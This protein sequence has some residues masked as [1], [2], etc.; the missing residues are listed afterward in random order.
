MM[1]SWLLLLAIPIVILFFSGGHGHTLALVSTVVSMAAWITGFHNIGRYS[2]S[3][4]RFLYAI[5][6][7]EQFNGVAFDQPDYPDDIA[8]AAGHSA[9]LTWRLE[10]L[11]R[12]GADGE[13]I[14]TD[15][16]LKVMALQAIPW[17]TKKATS[18]RN[19][20]QRKYEALRST[21]AI[22]ENL[23]YYF[24]GKEIPGRKPVHV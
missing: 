3:S 13:K 15:E 10:N 11:P 16:G 12:M 9:R 6:L 20:F 17:Q 2:K 7:I 22:Q 5:T 19:E 4:M 24:P 21:F 14:L 18:A 23:V 1:Y 8:R